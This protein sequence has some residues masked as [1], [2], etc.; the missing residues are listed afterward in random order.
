[1]ARDSQ[2]SGKGKNVASQ[3]SQATREGQ[4]GNPQE[5]VEQYHGYVS[6]VVGRL[7]KLMNLP[8]ALKE[9]FLSAGF[10]GL[11]EAAERFDPSKGHDFGAFAHLRIRG[12]VIDHI[13]RSSEISR[14]PYRVLKALEAAQSMRELAH[15]QKNDRSFDRR[16]KRA[17]ALAY[18]TKSAGA[19]KL[20]STVQERVQTYQ[21]SADSPERILSDKREF[22]KLRTIVATLPEKERM[23]V[24]QFYFQDRTFTEIARESAGVSKSWISRL[25]D[26]ALGILREKLVEDSK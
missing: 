19:F 15:E 3:R 1:M 21:D 5:L 9:D 6:K 13:R 23:I 22:E 8:A 25:H 11:V 2:R 16:S 12:A 14:R 20:A 26:R 7:I 10:L 17:L 18:L 4:G 24:E